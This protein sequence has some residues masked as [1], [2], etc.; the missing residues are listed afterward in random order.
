VLIC[1][2][3]AGRSPA[4]LQHATGKHAR[5][6]EQRRHNDEQRDNQNDQT[7]FHIHLLRRPIPQ[8]HRN[9]GIGCVFASGGIAGKPPYGQGGINN[10][11]SAMRGAFILVGIVMLAAGLLFTAQ[12]TGLFPY[13]RS[14]F[15]VSQTGWIYKGLG[16]AVVGLLL[17][18][19]GR[20][21]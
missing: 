20:R 21:R 3:P 14:S 1:G 6:V 7:H 9:V 18:L 8:R 11:G 2:W 5:R 16:I 17:I 10:K 4:P 19:A 15:M 12:G 13:P